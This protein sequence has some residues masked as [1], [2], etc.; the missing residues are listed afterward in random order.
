MLCAVAVTSWKQSCPHKQVTTLQTHPTPS[1]CQSPESLA[2]EPAPSPPFPSSAA[3]LWRKP[4]SPHFVH[5]FTSGALNS[6]PFSCSTR[7]VCSSSAL[8]FRACSCIISSTAPSTCLTLP[9]SFPGA[10]QCVAVCIPSQRR[11]VLSSSHPSGCRRGERRMGQIGSGFKRLRR[12]GC[13]QGKCAMQKGINAYCISGMHGQMPA[14]TLQTPPHIHYNVH[15]TKCDAHQ[16]Q[17]A[18]LQAMVSG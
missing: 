5:P 15:H 2:T 4:P 9:C 14:P 8:L 17:I 6:P 7:P 10:R 16:L 1:A 3:L 18:I 12:N 13:M 11:T